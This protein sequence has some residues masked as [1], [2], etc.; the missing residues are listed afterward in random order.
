MA[1]L[2][3]RKSQLLL[4]IKQLTFNLN[5]IWFQDKDFQLFL[6][7]VESHIIRVFRQLQFSRTGKCKQLKW[8]S[9]SKI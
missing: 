3:F 4:L 7:A 5:M 1:D 9:W 6:V 8:L 2:N